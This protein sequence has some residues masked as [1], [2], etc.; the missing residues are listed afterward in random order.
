MAGGGSSI[1]AAPVG[2]A[3]ALFLSGRGGAKSQQTLRD[4][5]RTRGPGYC[6]GAN[7]M[8]EDPPCRTAPQL[9][10]RHRSRVGHPRPDHA[11]PTGGPKP[12]RGDR[13]HAEARWTAVSCAFA[14]AAGQ[15]RLGCQPMGPKRRAVLLGF[16]IK[17][18]EHARTTGPQGAGGWWEQGRQQVQG[19]G[20]D[21]QWRAAGF[22]PPPGAVPNCV[23]RKSA[24]IAPGVV[25]MPSFVNLG[26]YVDAGTMVD[27]W[28]TVGS[29][30]QIGKNVHLSGGVGIGG[31]L[32]TD[33]GRPDDHRGTIASSAPGPRWSRA[34]SSGQVSVL[35]MGRPSSASPPR[36]STAKPERSCMA[37]CRPIR[38]S[39]PGRCPARTGSTLSLVWGP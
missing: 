9:E 33:A 21:N 34:V 23:V 37:R 26:A 30:A 22:P 13:G 20:G 2:F 31:V 35:G 3:L 10:A 24:Y 8:T 32:G 4:L 1:A 7:G 18:M 28:A 19:A 38:W 16:R 27:T 15:R 12:P 25:L 36:S 11:V 14:G 17:D 39:W 6:P 29:C 5:P